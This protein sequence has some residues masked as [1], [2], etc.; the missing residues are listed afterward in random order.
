VVEVHIPE[1]VEQQLQVRRKVM[2]VEAVAV[3]MLTLKPA[4]AAVQVQRV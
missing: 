4:E 2:Q 1:Q 3:P